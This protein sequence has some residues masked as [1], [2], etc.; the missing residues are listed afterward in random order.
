V[1]VEYR[2]WLLTITEIQL[3]VLEYYAF[4]NKS[5]K[6]GTLVAENYDIGAYG[7]PTVDERNSV[8][9]N[10]SASIFFLLCQMLQLNAFTGTFLCCDSPTAYQLF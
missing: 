4:T 1:V 3:Q 7:Y 5:P 2:G 6:I 10:S 9:C 8:G